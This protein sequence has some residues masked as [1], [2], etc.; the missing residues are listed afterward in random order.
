MR[1]AA[2]SLLTG[3]KVFLG[4]GLGFAEAV[5]FWGGKVLATG[6]AAEL[7]ALVGPNTKVVD[8]RGRLAVPGFND[9]HQHM[10]SMGFGAMEVDLKDEAIDTLD[11][12]L[13][14]VK[15]GVE[16]TEPGGW[17]LGRGYD[18]FEL[19]VKRHPLREELDQIA[20]DHPVY[21]KRTCGHMGVANSK[22]LELAGVTEGTSQPAGGHI[23]SQNGKLTGLMQETAQRLI[24]KAQ[25]DDKLE[26]LVTAIEAGARLNLSFGITSCTDP[27]VGLRKGYMDWQAYLA[28][29]RQDRLPIR[30]YLMPLAGASGWPDRAIGMDLMTGDGD[31]WMRVG[32]MKLFT[33]GSAGG[34]TA[35]MSEPY[36]DDSENT[37]IFIYGDEELQGYIADYH[38]RGFQIATHA[39]GD[40]AIEQVLSGYEKAMGNNVDPSRRH[41]I[42]HC[43]FLTDDQLRR[44]AAAGI[45][46][47]PQPIFLYEFGDLYLNVLGS[48]RPEASYPMRKW[49]AAGLYP[50]ASSD[51]PVSSTNPFRNLYTMVTR[52]TN[53]GTAIGADQ[54]LT[55]EEAI[56]AYTVNS[57]YGSFEEGIKG[58]LAP[59]MLGDVA[60]LDT[61][62]FA[63]EPEAWLSAHC[64][65]AI[66]GGVVAHDRL[67][68]VG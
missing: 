46:P 38:A 53:K 25:P 11:K 14:A 13:A 37:G 34:K 30:M 28:A 60:V 7:S 49:T 9:A 24:T 61:D 40:A 18:H 32:P 63:T 23:E 19:D 8:L 29:R 65:L 52:K 43:G 3:G 51:G 21:I 10:M 68:E 27:A 58:T 36:T 56:G 41:R 54:A 1:I 35:A 15:A 64:D 31:E 26:T 59:G 20:P 44:M 67:G 5:A 45:L 17:V 66:V 12:L 2:E 39:I 16:A 57:A 33:D 55:L 47:A 50:S 4:P 48:G 6:S 22:A 42:E 62:L